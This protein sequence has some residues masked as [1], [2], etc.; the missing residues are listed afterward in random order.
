MSAPPTQGWR[1]QW[2]G[3][4]GLVASVILIG[5]FYTEE[6]WRGQGAWE[7]CKRVLKAQ[8]VEPDW[9]NYIPDEVPDNQNVFGAPEM[10]KWFE[11]NGPGWADLAKDLPSLSFPC[12]SIDSNATRMIVARLTIGPPESPAPDGYAALRWNDPSSRAEA[13]KLVVKALGPTAK[14]PQSSIGVGLML[15]RPDD[16]QPAKI[17][18]RRPTAPTERE[19]QEFLPDAVILANAG[20]PERVLRFEPDGEASYRVTMPVLAR[21]ADFLS[22]SDALAPQFALIRQAL[23]LRSSRMQ[24]YYGNPSRIPGPNFRAIRSLAQTLGARAQCHLLLG[25][26]REALDELTLTD[27]FCR[28]VLEEEKPMT[29]LPAMIN[30]AVRGLYTA[31]IAEGLRLHAWRESELAALEE[32]LRTI[33]VVQPVKQAFMMEAIITFRDLQ[34]VPSAGMVRRSALSGLCPRGWGYQHLAARVQLDFDRVTS[35]DTANQVIYPDKI[36]ALVKKARELDHGSPYTFAASLGLAQDT[37]VRASQRAARIQTGVNQALIACALERYRLAR[38]EYPENLD[39]LVPRF[40]DHIPH[41]VI[42]GLSPRYRR[43]ANGSFVLYSIGWNGQDH[44]GVRGQ[45][46]TSMD[47]DWV[48]PD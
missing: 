42:G 35:F 2:W 9:T 34:S 31:Q 48:W 8:G 46:P 30:V 4:V 36:N 7:S 24:G 28:R 40:M 20:L 38:G 15:R 6:N 47:G 44:R 5:L 29:L 13:A 12:A 25:Q 27:D 37:F 18:L 16:I 11:A 14:S 41:D 39:A 32:Q 23:R 10:Q 3:L 22:W 33:D 21:A 17:F 45:S 26:P 19:L 1:T 43:A